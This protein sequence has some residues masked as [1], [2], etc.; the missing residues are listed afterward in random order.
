MI[1]GIFVSNFKTLNLVL[2]RM[3]ISFM[4]LGRWGGGKHRQKW[5]AV[6]REA[7]NGEVMVE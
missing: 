1:P 5:T 3:Y 6:E 2:S 4:L 7:M